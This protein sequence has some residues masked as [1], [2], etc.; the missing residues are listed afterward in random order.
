MWVKISSMKHPENRIWHDAPDLQVW[1]KEGCVTSGRARTVGSG[2]CVGGG[3][4]GSRI[5]KLRGSKRFRTCKR[6]VGKTKGW[7][8]S[9]KNIHALKGNANPW[10]FFIIMYI[11]LAISV[12]WDSKGTSVEHH[13]E[14]FLA[15]ILE[16]KILSWIFFFSTWL[17]P[18]RVHVIF[19]PYYILKVPKMYPRYHGNNNEKY[20]LVRLLL[21]A[22]CHCC[23]FGFFHTSGDG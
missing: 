17:V 16:F 14:Y 2:N 9:R 19:A 21:T 23:C 18:W 10:M 15:V 22:K 13:S 6:D 8:R 20:S 3:L 12:T 1:F 11:N 4:R 5:L 7:T